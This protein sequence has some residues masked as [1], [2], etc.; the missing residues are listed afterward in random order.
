L[1]TSILAALALSLCLTATAQTNKAPASQSAAAGADAPHATIDGCLHHPS[2]DQFVLQRAS[3]KKYFLSGERA[4]LEGLV[5]K[6]IRV[7]GTLT[8]FNDPT[9]KI[10]TS[11]AQSESQAPEQIT[12]STIHKIGDDC[13]DGSAGPQG[14]P[15]VAGGGAEE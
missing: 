5:E 11:Y 10:G 1:K 6:E 14:T 13:A 9:P 7:Y 12:I 4:K 8:T 15:V 2:K 3:G